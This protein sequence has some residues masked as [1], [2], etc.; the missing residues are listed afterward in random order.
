LLEIG[1]RNVGQQTK[2]VPGVS[3]S[4]GLN[5]LYPSVSRSMQ[6]ALKLR[7]LKQLAAVDAISAT[8]RWL[9]LTHHHILSSHRSYWESIGPV[10]EL[11]G[12]N[13]EVI[14]KRGS[15]R[16]QRKRHLAT[17]R[18]TQPHFGAIR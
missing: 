13:P 5:P 2:G 3:T 18:I 17:P 1:G 4:G 15:R 9:S 6:L 14:Q 12:G 11:V 8:R 16:L 7:F 10:A